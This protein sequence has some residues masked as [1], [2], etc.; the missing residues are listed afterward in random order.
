[1]MLHEETPVSVPPPPPR[2]GQVGR[3]I[4]SDAFTIRPELARREPIGSAPPGPPVRVAVPPRERERAPVLAAPLRAAGEP[5]RDERAAPPPRPEKPP[6]APTPVQPAQVQP[7][8]A[9]PRLASPLAE[10]AA[11]SL[12]APGPTWLRGRAGGREAGRVNALLREAFTPTRPKRDATLFAGRFREM[13]RIIAAI[14]EERAHVVIYGERGSGKTSLSNILAGKA[15]DAGYTVLQFACTSGVS[16]EEIFRS[17]LRRIPAGFLAE[18][19]GG[20]AR[21][22]NFEQLLPDRAVG[23]S[24]VADA[25]AMIHERHVILIIDEYDRV[26]SD[27]VKSRLAELIKI[28]SDTSAPA[29][30]L[31]IGVADDVHELFG[32]HP[33]LQRTLVT[34]PMPLMTRR[35]LETLIAAGEARA[36]LT[37]APAVRDGIVEFAQG[38]PY[39]AQL[40]CLFAARSAGRRHSREV[41][42]EDLRYAVERAADEAESRIKEAYALAL[43]T[44]ADPV[45]EDTLYHAARARSDE[46]GAFTADDVASCGGQDVSALH[47]PLLR[48]TEAGRGAVLRRLDGAR[49]VRFQF[50]SQMLRH[51]VLARQAAQRGLI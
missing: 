20:R 33:S 7:A 8:P 23:V 25:F 48:L 47:D 35:E 10:N 11:F 41:V 2:T 50:A 29:T 27:E 9:P 34:V 43:G 42:A 22:E 18:G 13:Q 6:A 37:F 45:L 21:V 5:S 32:K 31:L 28:M 1:M 51:H 19:I 39:H 40:L 24:E 3:V 17:L 15:T 46:F 49:G 14:E 12:A 44:P 4:R 26:V 16:F 36:E 38:L 30:L